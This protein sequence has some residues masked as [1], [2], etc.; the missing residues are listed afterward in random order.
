ME[1]HNLTK[2]SSKSKKRL[3][4]GFG[5]GRGGHT[6]SRGQKGQKARRTIYP[7]FEGTKNKKSLLQRLPLLRGK[8]KLKS[9]KSNPQVVTLDA[10][11]KLPQ[12]SLVDVQLLVSQGLAGRPA[13]KQGV[14]ILNS[15]KITKKLKILLPA[16]RAAVASIIKAGGTVENELGRTT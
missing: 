6:S 3:G 14:K 12:N 13:L 10:L 7:L 4:H 8:G 11:D 1:L 15:G 16:S 5:S 2:T 9:L